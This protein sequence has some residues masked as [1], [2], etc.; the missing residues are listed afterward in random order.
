MEFIESCAKDQM[1]NFVC[2]YF[3][4]HI[5]SALW[6]CFSSP[7]ISSILFSNGF[8]YFL[9]GFIQSR[10]IL[11]RNMLKFGK[12]HYTTSLLRIK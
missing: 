4:S 6:L 9:P 7:M 1:T 2:K 11:H 10:C 8:F 12:T 3:V 5:L